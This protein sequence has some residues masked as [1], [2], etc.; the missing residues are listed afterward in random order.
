[1]GYILFI[2]AFIL[3]LIALPFG[4]GVMLYYSFKDSHIGNGFKY[5]NKRSYN[6]SYAFDCFAN[7]AFPELWTLLFSSKTS[8]HKFGNPEEPLS[9]VLGKLQIENSL[10]KG[11]WRMVNIL[12]FVCR[13]EHC[14]WTVQDYELKNK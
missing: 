7:A 9:Y 2:V 1:M 10:G 3:F 6:M 14:L 8:L 4:L 5:G 12:R 11:G 13:K